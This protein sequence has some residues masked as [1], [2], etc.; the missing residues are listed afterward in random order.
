[1]TRRFAV[2]LNGLSGGGRGPAQAARPRELFGP[3]TEVAL[4]LGGAAIRAAA[5]RL[6]AAGC[7]ALIAGGGD[8]TAG[9]VAG[10]ARSHA[11]PLGVLPLG[12]LNHFAKDLGMPT[13]LDAAAEAIAGSSPRAVDAGEANG[14]LFLNNA[15][16][17]V[18]PRLVRLRERH[19]ARGTGKWLAA[20]WA[21]L[22]V[23]RRHPFFDVALRTTE[24]STRRRTPFVMIANNAYR[25]AGL[26]PQTRERLDAGELAVYTYQ[27]TGRSSLLL[28]GLRVVLLGVDR[29][30]ELEVQTSPEVTVATPR[31][32]PR[33]AL[34][35]ELTDLRPP[36]VARILPRALLV[37]APPPAIE[38]TQGA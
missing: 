20:L 8:G 1:V 5:E 34:D 37:L 9:T 6:A 17:G 38:T 23:L 33:L 27:A 7:D 32:A 15:S 14:E 12:T 22:A 29:V 10:V 2:V 16:L 11:L 26:Q 28:L 3:S 30:R 13:T 18:Y 21:T 4:V 31:Q 35:G 19:R 25:M 36:L 24:Q